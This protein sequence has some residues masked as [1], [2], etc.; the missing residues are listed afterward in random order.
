MLRYLDIHSITPRYV[1]A[2]WI[3]WASFKHFP[4]LKHH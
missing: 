4:T 3:E 2:I 1:F